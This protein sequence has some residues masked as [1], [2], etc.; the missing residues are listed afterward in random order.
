MD[1]NTDLFGEIQID[2]NSIINFEAGLPGFPDDKRF[3]LVEDKEYLTGVFCCLQSLDTPSVAFTLLDTFSVMPEYNPLVDEADISDI[4]NYTDEDLEV[5]NILLIA[6]AVIDITVNLKAPII[7]N[8]K[9][10]KGKQVIVDNDDY[11][12]K[13]RI[14]E[15]LKKGKQVT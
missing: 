14:F 1:I 10:K 4:G 11:S 15:K 7:I 3:T 2:E 9:S 8:V 5:Y 13:Y 6:D 12:T